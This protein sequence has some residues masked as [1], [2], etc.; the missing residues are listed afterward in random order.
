MTASVQ[1]SKRKPRE[2]DLSEGSRPYKPRGKCKELFERK[3]KL[4][5]LDGPAGTGKSTAALN[6]IYYLC[7]K[8]PGIR[9]LIVRKTREELT[10][11]ALVTWEEVVVPVGDPILSG[12]Q[13][14][15]R[16]EYVF[17]NGSRVIVAGLRQSSRDN[18]QQIMS[19]DYD[20]IFIMEAVSLSLEEWEKL[21]T[22][23][24]HGKMPYQQIIADTNP[25]GDQHWLNKLCN[26][27]KCVR[28]VTKHED[29][30]RWWD[31]N[32]QA[33]T[34]QG[35][36]Y[37]A[38]LDD[39]TGARKQRLRFGRWVQAE[40][41]V[42]ENWS[43]DTHVIKPFEI[44]KFWRRFITIDFGYTNAFVALFW[45]VDPDDRMY[46]YREYVKTKMIV[47]EHAEFLKTFMINDGVDFEAII[48]DPEDAEGRAT[49]EKILGRGTIGA[50]KRDKRANIQSM[51]ERL[52]VQPDGKARLYVF[53]TA[54]VERDPHMEEAK[55]PIGIIEEIDG[56]V[57]KPP[58]PDK[59]PKEEPV[60]KDNHSLDSC[61]YMVAHLQDDVWVAPVDLN[62]QISMSAPKQDPASGEI[63]WRDEFDRA[64]KA[65]DWRRG[66]GNWRGLNDDLMND[67]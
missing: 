66:S 53:D 14:N 35:T 8:Y 1:V 40:G 26:A 20:V 61:L 18:T 28:L 13:R 12:P 54:L 55:K 25:A 6:K 63:N 16:K 44:S 29:N 15:Q 17:P 58:T 22:R 47:S 51:E 62:S 9:A 23:L 7:N 19:T 64:G 10:Q 43:V 42:Y 56:Y 31:E 2:S 32:K 46:L 65:I 34:P 45:A 60:E 59:P 33:W 36:D 21:T 3:E 11:S 67:I 4:V 52:K 24:R 49:L 5:L 50:R 41:V 37:I 38:T 48:C 30:P 27:G 57:W 39:L